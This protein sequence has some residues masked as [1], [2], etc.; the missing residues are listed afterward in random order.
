MITAALHEDLSHVSYQNH[1]VFGLMIPVTC[2]GVPADIL[3]PRNTWSDKEAY[4][5]QTANLA[6]Q[7]VNNFKKYKDCVSA[8]ILK[9]APASISLN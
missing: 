1:P 7:F 2:P 4:D 6:Q 9:A 8:E 3:N 5:K